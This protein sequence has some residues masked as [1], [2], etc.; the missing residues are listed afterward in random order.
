MKSKQLLR[1]D[2]Q[3]DLAEADLAEEIPKILT[4][5]DPNIRKNLVIY[6]FKEGG[7]VY[8][9]S[10]KIS[11]INQKLNEKYF[12]L[13]TPSNTVTLFQFDGTAI[14]K[15]SAEAKQQMIEMGEDRKYLIY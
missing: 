8:V 12:Q 3:L 11:T 14:H 7:Y 1:P 10:K 2:D 13:P 6:S 15:E 5:D 4:A 9:S